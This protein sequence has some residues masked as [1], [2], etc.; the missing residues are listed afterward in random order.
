MTGETPRLNQRET[1]MGGVLSQSDLD[2]SSREKKLRFPV[3]KL[4]KITEE[5]KRQKELLAQLFPKPVRLHRLIQDIEKN[6]PEEFASIIGSVDY[7]EARLA[8]LLAALRELAA[9]VDT[10]TISHE[11]I[12]EHVRQDTRIHE[13]FEELV[14]DCTRFALEEVEA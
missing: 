1:S 9:K 4:E 6:F 8:G 3:L 12:D 10:R 13:L 5:R 7:A 14:L 11:E 2:P